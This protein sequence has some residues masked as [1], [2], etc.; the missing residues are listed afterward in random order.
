MYFQQHRI[1]FTLLIFSF[2]TC[3]CTLS[4]Y[5]LQHV[6]LYFFFLKGNTFFLFLLIRIYMLM[7]RNLDSTEDM[8]NAKFKLIFFLIRIS[9][10]PFV[11]PWTIVPLSM[12]FSRPEF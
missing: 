5:T 3:Y 2:L 4:G 10:N 6:D 7:I 1:L 12:E 8:K 11:T 9:L